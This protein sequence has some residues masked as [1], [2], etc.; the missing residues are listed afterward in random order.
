MV[1]LAVWEFLMSEEPLWGCG[2]AGVH[3]GFG[4]WSVRMLADHSPF[5]PNPATPNYKRQTPQ[6]ETEGGEGG[7]PGH[8]HC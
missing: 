7:C 8:G 1:I 3:R 4:V 2:C 5:F 6:P